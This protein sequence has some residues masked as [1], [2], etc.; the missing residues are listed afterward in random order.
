ME[1]ILTYLRETPIFALFIIIAIGFMVGKINIKGFSFDVAAVIFVA[2]LFGHYGIVVSPVLGSSIP[3]S[4]EG[5][6]TWCWLSCWCWY[7]WLRPWC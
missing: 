5:V 2:L 7:R 3:S 1:A 6:N 4:R